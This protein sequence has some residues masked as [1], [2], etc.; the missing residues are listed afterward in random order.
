MMKVVMAARDFDYD[1]KM[2]PVLFLQDGKAETCTR[3]EVIGR[4][5]VIL[6][7]FIT[8]LFCTMQGIS[9]YRRMESRAATAALLCISLT[10]SYI[11]ALPN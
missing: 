6:A 7:V 1:D 2:F 11:P 3:F 5:R 9:S 10:S 8:Q 4:A